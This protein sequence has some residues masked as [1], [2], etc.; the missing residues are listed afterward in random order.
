MH[1]SAWSAAQPMGPARH[2][3]YSHAAAAACR[4]HALRPSW[5]NDLHATIRA[6]PA[7]LLHRLR[8]ELFLWLQEIRHPNI[9]LF[10][11]MVLDPPAI[12][13][14]DWRGRQ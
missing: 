10:M 3:P 5:I 2:A 8:A 12:V 1:G 14:G 9:I 13:T 7:S 6:A 4:R 11:G